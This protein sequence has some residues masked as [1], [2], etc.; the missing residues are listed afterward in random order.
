[1]VNKNVYLINF[2]YLILPFR[3]RMNFCRG[4]PSQRIERL[5][6]KEIT[7]LLHMAKVV[8]SYN[9]LVQDVLFRSDCFQYFLTKK[10]PSK[11]NSGII[12]SNQYSLFSSDCIPHCQCRRTFFDFST[13]W[14]IF[15]SP[16]M[17]FHEKVIWYDSHFLVPSIFPADT[18]Y[19]KY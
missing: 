6:K 7:S 10:L 17:G 5:K 18:M 12:N 3:E 19:I 14:N 16:E 2:F 11:E 9:I 1:M 13:L 8:L 4:I 15:R